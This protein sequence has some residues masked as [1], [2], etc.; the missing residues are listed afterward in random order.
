MVYLGLG[1]AV[2]ISHLIFGCANVL[3][4]SAFA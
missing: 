1:E 2:L 3:V 4:H